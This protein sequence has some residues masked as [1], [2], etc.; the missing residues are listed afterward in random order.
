M[1]WAQTFVS[2]P[3]KRERGSQEGRR[4]WE[5]YVSKVSIPFKRERGSQVN[6]Y[7]YWVIEKFVSIPFKRER[8]S[9]EVG[10]TPCSSLGLSC[11]NS[12]QT[13]TRIARLAS[14]FQTEGSEDGFQFPSNGE[15]GSQ[16]KGLNPV[17]DTPDDSFNSLQ[18]GTRIAS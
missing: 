2:I 10:H 8:G 1:R 3:F 16:A 17:S 6:S 5:D 18:T 13:G 14:D 4:L 12:L 9:Q 11:F 15:R 7:G